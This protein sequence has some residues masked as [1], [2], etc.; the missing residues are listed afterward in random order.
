VQLP[1]RPKPGPPLP[2]PVENKTPTGNLLGPPAKR[3][4]KTP[5]RAPAEGAE[6][7]AGEHFER[8]NAGIVPGESARGGGG[9]SGQAGLG[10]GGP[11]S[12]QRVAGLQPGAGGKGLGGGV[13][14]LARPL[15]GY[16]IKPHYPE[17]ARRQ[18]IEGTTLLKIYVSERGG[19]KDIL[20]E[21]SAGYQ[22]LDL[23]ALRA[24][25]KWRFEPA[26]QGNRPIAVWVVLPVH[27]ALR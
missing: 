24:V 2:L 21:R 4:A 25:K 6:A 27:F 10:T 13:G 19:V 7:G 16:Q 11:G 1:T 18:G 5:T 12:N 20:I 15:G 8:G 26:K 22:A 14:P 23:A 9:G 17:S 3:P